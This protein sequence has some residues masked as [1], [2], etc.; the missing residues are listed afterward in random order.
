MLTIQDKNGTVMFKQA[1]DGKKSDLISFA[2]SQALA[3]KFYISGFSNKIGGWIET[4]NGRGQLIA[5]TK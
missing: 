2:K 3:A 1:L 4:Y 5:T